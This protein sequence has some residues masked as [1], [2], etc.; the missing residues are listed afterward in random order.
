MGYIR[1]NP[2]VHPYLW[3]ITWDPSQ[4]IATRPLAIRKDGTWFA[5]GWNI[6]NN[7]CEIFG[8]AGYIRTVYTYSP[9][10]KVSENGDTEQ[11]IQWNGEHYRH[12][13]LPQMMDEYFYQN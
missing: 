8:P 5:Y 9:Y 7:I 13:V 6:T 3:L 1:I 11:S 10:G 12:Y 4:P 2:I